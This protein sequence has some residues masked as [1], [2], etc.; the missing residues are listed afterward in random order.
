MS[1]SL[2]LGAYYAD[3]STLD[4]RLV[5]SITSVDLEE[6][7]ST[8]QLL[9]YAQ[10]IIAVTRAFMGLDTRDLKSITALVNT[11]YLN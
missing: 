9:A 7:A 11:N 5:K 10:N 6:S 8:H 3:I 2:C 4:K 1:K